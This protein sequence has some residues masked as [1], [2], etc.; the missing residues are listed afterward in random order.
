VAAGSPGARLGLQP[1]SIPVTIGNEELLIGGDVVLQIQS[2]PVSPKAEEICVLQNVVGGFSREK[3]I[4]V[5]VFRKGE[6]V[7]LSTGR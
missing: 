2:I 5:T 4:R 6:V 1:G 3:D 7:H